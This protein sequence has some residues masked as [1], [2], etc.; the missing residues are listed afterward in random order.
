MNNSANSI[1]LAIV[2]CI[3]AYS[4]FTCLD[5]SA[6]WLG[7]AGMSV[8]QIAFVRYATHFAI[9][10][11]VLLPKERSRLFRTGHLPL[12]M[13]RGLF[14]AGSTLFNFMALQY[15][16]LTVTISLFFLIPLFICIFSIPI[17]GE[18]VG[19]RRWVAVLIGFSGIL[20]ITQPWSQD[21]HPAALFSVCAAMCGALYTVL[22]RKLAPIDSANTQQVYGGLTGTLMLLP[23]V[24]G[25]WTWPEGG[26]QWFPFIMIGIFGWLGHLLLTIGH[27]YAEATVLAPFIYT[28]ILSAITLS[29]L[30]FAQ[31]PDSRTLAGLAII[32][33]SGLY[34][35]WRERTL[36]QKAN[37]ST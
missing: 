25:N 19:I 14:L 12:E 33:G 37:P 36:G 34:I 11:A 5:S 2:L 4:L 9:A 7:L 17:L 16:P 22:T 15:L 24:I 35:W 31:P 29:W 21:W 32:M 3:C 27:R 30:I 13:L 20:V 28:Q 18:K 26:D 6:K 1:S 10:T 8:F 23:F